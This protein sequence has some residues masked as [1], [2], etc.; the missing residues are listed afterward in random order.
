[1]RL[2]AKID[3][4]ESK[5]DVDFVRLE[6][7]ID[8]LIVTLER[9]L[10]PSRRTQDDSHDKDQHNGFHFD[11]DDKRMYYMTPLTSIEY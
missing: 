10:D 3:A 4:G 6:S 8:F 7:K 9:Q 5:R 11:D 1:M 2:E